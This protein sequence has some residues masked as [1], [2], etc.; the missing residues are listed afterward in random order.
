LGVRANVPRS[1]VR[2]SAAST[3]HP[4]GPAEP[5][6]SG[7]EFGDLARGGVVLYHP[8]AAGMAAVA[9]LLRRPPLGAVRSGR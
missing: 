1:T 5:W 2:A 7:G 3:G 6:V 4:A 8:D 9:D